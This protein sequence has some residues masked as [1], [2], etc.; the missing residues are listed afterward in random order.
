MLVD[1]GL[2]AGSSPRERS[3]TFQHATLA[4]HLQGYHGSIPTHCKVD[5]PPK[6]SHAMCVPTP[7]IQASYQQRALKLD[8]VVASC[9]ELQRHKRIERVP[10]RE[11]RAHHGDAQGPGPR[12]PPTQTLPAR[13]SPSPC[14]CSW[15]HSRP[16]GRG[17]GVGQASTQRSGVHKRRR[18]GGRGG[19][20]IAVIVLRW[21]PPLQPPPPWV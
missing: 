4:G 10:K 13:P 11:E 8:G 18:L 5:P 1:S 3:R 16:K 7:G 21:R 12:V 15:G 20:K 14:C 6:S 2:E 9:L 19:L 17:R